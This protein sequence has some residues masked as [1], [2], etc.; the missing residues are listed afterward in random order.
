MSYYKKSDVKNHLSARTPQPVRAVPQHMD[1]ASLPEISP[2]VEAADNAQV[3]PFH[4]IGKEF[5]AQAQA[6]GG[7]GAPSGASRPKRSQM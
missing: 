5:P 6:G 2:G 3:I 7:I 4:P 1:I